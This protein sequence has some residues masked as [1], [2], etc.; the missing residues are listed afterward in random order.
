LSHFSLPKFTAVALGMSG[1]ALV[2]RFDRA[3]RLEIR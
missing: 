1:C 2:A 3:M